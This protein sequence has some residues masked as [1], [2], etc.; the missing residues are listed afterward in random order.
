MLSGAVARRY[1]LA[2][3]EIGVANNSLD[4]LVLE[5]KSVVTFLKENADANKILVHPRIAVEDKKSLLRQLF[6]S[7]ISETASNFLSLLVD[8]KREANLSEVVEEL[9]EMLNRAKNIAQAEVVSAMELNPE[10]VEQIKQKLA[11]STGK[12]I[13]LS[14]RVDASLVGGI[15][16]RIGDTVIDGSVKNRLKALKEQ[17]RNIS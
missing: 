6:H 15:V 3:Y 8:R 11:Q 9:V 13:E 7:A 14:T 10:Q 4:S 16:V 2:L 12:I 5:L 1:A 17:L